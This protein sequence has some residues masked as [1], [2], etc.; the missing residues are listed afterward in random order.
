M[1]SML[2]A[3]PA[4]IATLDPPIAAQGLPGQLA[5]RR[6]LR[7]DACRHRPGSPAAPCHLAG[8]FRGRCLACPPSDTADRQRFHADFA[9]VGLAPR[10]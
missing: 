2:S 1:G 3:G 8:A 6:R 7:N 10:P 9:A 5:L 4:P